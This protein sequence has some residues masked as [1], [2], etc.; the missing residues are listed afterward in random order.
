MQMPRN[1]P[2]A[3]VG[4]LHAD[5]AARVCNINAFAHKYR[6]FRG[7]G[8]F[9]LWRIQIPGRPALVNKSHI[10]A[11][12][13]VQKLRLLTSLQLYSY[14]IS[15][16]I[17]TAK[18]SGLLKGP[19]EKTLNRRPCLDQAWDLIFAF[20]GFFGIFALPVDLIFNFTEY[21]GAF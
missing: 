9:R 21:K 3:E 17:I 2:V 15:P 4:F 5:G 7:S 18:N 11:Q 6:R 16:I 20:F 19:D 13:G 1:R 14:S 12:F 8:F 10:A